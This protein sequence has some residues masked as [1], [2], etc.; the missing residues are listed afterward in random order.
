MMDFVKITDLT[1][2]LGI[3][4]RTL[5]YYEQMGLVQSE[6]LQ[7]E[8]YRFYNQ[9]NIERVKQILVLSKMQI[10][11]KDIVKIYQGRD[12]TVLVDSFIARSFVSLPNIPIKLFL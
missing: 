2:Q 12:M 11:V 10:P 9:E 5:R 6:R 4:S 1:I 7:I 8:K 3:S